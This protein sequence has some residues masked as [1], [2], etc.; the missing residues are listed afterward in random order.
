MHPATGRFSGPHSGKQEANGAN[1]LVR[2]H[3]QICHPRRT[4]LLS[5]SLVVLEELTV[6]I[7][8]WDTLFVFEEPKA[9]YFKLEFAKQEEALKD[10]STFRWS[11]LSIILS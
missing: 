10:W 1:Q 11:M 8:H 6:C 5:K 7:P 2:S 3:G 9:Y 4:M